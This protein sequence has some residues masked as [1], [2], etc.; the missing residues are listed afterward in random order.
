MQLLHVSQNRYFKQQARIKCPIKTVNDNRNTPNDSQERRNKGDNK[1]SNG[2]IPPAVTMSS[3]WLSWR[4][5]QVNQS[6]MAQT[7]L[8]TSAV[9]FEVILET[10]RD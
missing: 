5:K 1:T 2:E 7:A 8:P 10:E 9:Q 4:K 6:S 3:D